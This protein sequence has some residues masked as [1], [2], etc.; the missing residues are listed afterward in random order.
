MKKT[1]APST[2]TPNQID[3]FREA[4]RELETDQSEEAFD[5][6]LKKIAKAPPPVQQGKPSR[7][8]SRKK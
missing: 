1:K 8:G 6:A 4:A 5:R 2:E 3:K 7:K